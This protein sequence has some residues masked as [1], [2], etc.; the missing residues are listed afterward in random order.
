MDIKTCEQYVLD[1]LETAEKEN[2]AHLQVIEKLTDQLN[3][4]RKLLTLIKD[5]LEI[6]RSSENAVILS[7]CVWDK[8][9]SEVY[10]KLVEGLDLKIP[11]Q[12]DE[13]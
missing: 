8:F 9:E 3:N 1:R 7:L 6:R 13:D 12:E 10:K 4:Y 2:S 5:N 11:E